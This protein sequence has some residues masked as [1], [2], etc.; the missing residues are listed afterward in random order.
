MKIAVI[1]GL[2]LLSLSL[3]AQAQTPNPQGCRGV[4]LLGEKV[5]PG[6]QAARKGGAPEYWRWGDGYGATQAAPPSDNF[7][8]SQSPPFRSGA[9][10][11]FYGFGR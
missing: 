2:A 6:C 10:N 3:S 9:Y 4:Y 8:S 7:R 5:P 1:A 11:S